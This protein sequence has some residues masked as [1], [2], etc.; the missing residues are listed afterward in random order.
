MKR[1]RRHKSI[2]VGVP[3]SQCE[4]LQLLHLLHLM[5]R[6]CGQGEGREAEAAAPETMQEMLA[7]MI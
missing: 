5:Q 4:L 1:N 6:F 2:A 3:L 7:L